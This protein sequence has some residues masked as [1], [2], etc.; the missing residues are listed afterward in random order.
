MEIAVGIIVYV[1]FKKGQKGPSATLLG[2]WK[3]DKGTFSCYHSWER[4][5]NALGKPGED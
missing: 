5:L 2:V 3:N 1:I 4:L